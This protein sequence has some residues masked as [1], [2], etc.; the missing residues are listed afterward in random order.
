MVSFL[1]SGM[2]GTTGGAGGAGGAT[3]GRGAGC[4]SFLFQILT[5]FSF[6]SMTAYNCK[7]TGMTPL[8]V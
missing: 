1:I 7:T 3:A 2:G 5:G 8:S 4:S 6:Y